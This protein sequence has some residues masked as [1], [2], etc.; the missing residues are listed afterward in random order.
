MTE[1][2][3]D[4][5]N[6]TANTNADADQDTAVNIYMSPPGRGGKHNYAQGY[7]ASD[8]LFPPYPKPPP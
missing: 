4:I 7:M 5:S 3:G 8:G 6:Q 1:R 2:L